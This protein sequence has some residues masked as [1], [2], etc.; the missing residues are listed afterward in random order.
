VTTDTTGTGTWDNPLFDLAKAALS[1][2]YDRNGR[3]K[4]LTSPL[5][6][7]CYHY[8]AFGAVDTLTDPA[9]TRHDFGYDAAGRL[10]TLAAIASIPR[11]GST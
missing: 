1:Y 10:D 11:D 5:G 3:R 8:A 4:T 2:T 9:G 7:T 6:G